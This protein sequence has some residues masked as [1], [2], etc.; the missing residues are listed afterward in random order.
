MVHVF[1]KATKQLI[2]KLRFLSSHYK[3]FFCLRFD[4]IFKSLYVR[5]LINIIRIYSQTLPH[6]REVGLIDS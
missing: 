6:F 3:F 5:D 2:V 1:M 4:A